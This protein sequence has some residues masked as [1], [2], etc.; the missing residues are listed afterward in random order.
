MPALSLST[1]SAPLNS[2]FLQGLASPEYKTILAAARP[3]HYAA[4]SVVVNQGHPADQLFLLTSGRAR[5]F[6]NT[7]EGRKLLLLWLTPGDI[8]GG[9][10]LTLAPSA[11]LLSTETLKDSSM[12][13]W[14]RKTIR[15]LAARYPQLLDN[16]L[17]DASDY[18][19]WYVASHAALI[20]HTARQ[21][22]ARVV[23][24]LAETIGTRVSEGLEFDATNEEL[25]GAA[26][27]SPFT[28]SRLLAGWQKK[29][30]LVKRRGKILL[31]SPEHLLGRAFP[32]SPVSNLSKKLLNS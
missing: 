8:I 22:F 29:Q 31:R 2:R 23:T 7:Y 4:N 5:F 26:N 28:V 9:M 20:S 12:L 30:I 16:A 3:R 11:Y 15:G 32:G 19:G 10:A 14:D 1:A 6:F 13:V 17:L 27:V 25:A 18:L 21:R 24:C